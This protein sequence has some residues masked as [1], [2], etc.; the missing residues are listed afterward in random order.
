M[1]SGPLDKDSCRQSPGPFDGRLRRGGEFP[2]SLFPLVYNLGP[3]V[4][5]TRVKGPKRSLPSTRPP[6]SEPSFSC[7]FPYHPLPQTPN[8]SYSLFSS[9][10]VR[11]V[12]F[13][14]LVLR[15]GSPR[16][17]LRQGRKASPITRNLKPV[18]ENWTCDDTT[19]ECR[20]PGQT[21]YSLGRT[22]VFR[23]TRLLFQVHLTLVP[24]TFPD[25]LDSLTR[26]S[27]NLERKK[28]PP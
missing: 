10:W 8:P 15:R 21:Y 20:V 17:S 27:T 14:D 13:S 1:G 4:R 26:R 18:A 23:G 11:P 22:D 5:K 9:L 19:R 6:R 2:R 28:N 25:L 16:S 7:I 12:R 24:P 3:C